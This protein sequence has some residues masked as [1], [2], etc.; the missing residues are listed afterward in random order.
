MGGLFG[1]AW[2]KIFSMNKDV[3]ILLVGLDA[4]GKTT[5]MY[6]LKMDE[7]V[8]TIP[9]VGFNVETMNYKNL[10]ITMWDVGGQDR[11]RALWNHYYSGT[12]AVIYVID[13]CDVDRIE[14]SCY[15]LHKMLEDD[16]LAKASVLIYANKQDLTGALGPNEIVERM[17]LSDLKRKW[18][19]QGSSALKGN[20]LTEGLDW[21]AKVLK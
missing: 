5:I 10:S 11:I 4:A 7:T 9:T 6:K 13:S 14:E 12:D 2:N 3:R 18:M 20:G 15:E 21:I 17:K 1:K 8:R 16:E 19:V